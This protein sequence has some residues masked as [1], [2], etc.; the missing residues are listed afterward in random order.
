MGNGISSDGNYCIYETYFVRNLRAINKHWEVI[1]TH[2]SWKSEL[3]SSLSPIL[4]RDGRLCIFMMAGDSLGIMTLGTPSVEYIPHV[5]S[6]KMQENGSIESLVYLSDSA[7]RKLVIRDLV[8][9]E[10]QLFSQVKDFLFSVDGTILL[11]ETTSKKDDSTSIQAL[12]WINL[13]NGRRADIWHGEGQAGNFVF[14]D[15]NAEIAFT[16]TSNQNTH[17][18][19][20]FWYFKDGSDNA[21]LL[22]DDRSP[23]I[24]SG[25]VLDH[26]IDFSS[27]NSRLFISLKEM[28]PPKPKVEAVKVNVW[29]YT[30]ARLQSEQLEELD[31]RNYTAVMPLANHRIMRLESDKDD[32]IVSAVPARAYPDYIL[33]L[34]LKGTRDEWN[35]NPAAQP[36][37]YLVST[38]NGNRKQILHAS[39]DHPFSYCDL[40]PAGKY[41]IY[42]DVKKRNYFSYSVSSG[43]IRNITHGIVAEW[44]PIEDEEPGSVYWPRGS[45]VAWTKGDVSLMLYDR[46]D[47]WQIDPAGLRPA[48]N[49]TNG[50]GRRHGIVLRLAMPSPIA[51]N[52]DETIL[53]KAFNERTKD[54]GFYQKGINESGDPEFLTMGHYSYDVPPVKAR[55]AKVYLVSRMSAMEHP[56]LFLTNNFK[57]FTPVTNIYPERS[58]NWLTSELITWKTFNGSLS[59]GV[60]YKPENF[61]PKLKYPVIFLY[62]ERL[63]DELNLYRTPGPSWGRIDIPTFVSNG[64]LVF[65]PDIHYAIGKLGE[66]VVNAVVS[67]ARYLSGMPWVDARKMGINGHSFGGYETDYLVTHTHLFA[68]AVSGSGI[69]DLVSDY[70]AL[71]DGVKGPSKKEYCELRGFRIG[72]TLWQRPDLYIKNS[73][74]FTADKVTTPLLMMNNTLDYAVPFSQGVEFFT[75]LRRLGR[76][77]W[78][79]QYDEMGHTAIR[80]EGT[81]YQIRVTQFFDHYLK[82]LPPPM[83]MTEGI[84]ASRKGLDSGLELD[85]RRGIEP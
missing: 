67:A 40:S 45:I 42:Y 74:I 78:M 6:F 8:T 56:N 62:Y 60:L 21:V 33:I 22:A 54:N 48:V 32:L 19:H 28:D 7:H 83:W 51:L 10:Q 25:L 27:D 85:T 47:L 20:S 50:Y 4:S 31:P 23:C 3:P 49:L 29:S 34:N 80:K 75:A 1:S 64:Y 44:T 11:L 46:Y 17:S 53:L 76:K 12:D 9:G 26:I 52:G 13:A 37:A 72:A 77:A 82:G 55:D 15:E 79:L 5:S 24:E 57:K 63:S 41:V 71:W 73:P 68:A 58:Y 61:D 70:G 30:D 39:V 84:P 18:L 65:T 66:S 14:G 36:A 2:G 43:I 81:D 38:R 69:S 59:Q 16:V 35:W